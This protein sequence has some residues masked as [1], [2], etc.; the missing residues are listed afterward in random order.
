MLIDMA[1]NCLNQKQGWWQDVSS[2]SAL[3]R[4]AH[5]PGGWTCA[6]GERCLSLTSDVLVPTSTC[7]SVLE[8]FYSIIGGE[9]I[10]G[11]HRPTRDSGLV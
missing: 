5:S 8:V 1:A 9:L 11:I 6:T 2:K 10:L 3:W 7:R 4:S